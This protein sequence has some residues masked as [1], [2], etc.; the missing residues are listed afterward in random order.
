MTA[1]RCADPDGL[2]RVRYTGLKLVL[3]STDQMLF[4]PA[5][6][7]PGSGTAVVLKRTDALRVEFAAPGAPRNQTC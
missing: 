3:R 4:L 5:D 7:T 2:Y 6:W 1:T